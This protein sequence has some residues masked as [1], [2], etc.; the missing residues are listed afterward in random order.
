MT[1][2]M[3]RSFAILLAALALAACNEKPEE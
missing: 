1:M 3:K 2:N